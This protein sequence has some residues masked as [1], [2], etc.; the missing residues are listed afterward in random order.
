MKNTSL[1]NAIKLGATSLSHRVVM[2][3]LTRL[4]SDQDGDVP[5][6]LMLEYYRQR[7]SAGGLIITEATAVA[8]NGRGYLGAPGIYS[9][10][11][12]DGW[13]RITD[14]VH[15][16]GGRIFLQLWHV[17]RVSHV[18]MTGGESPVAPSAI[19]FEGAAFT[20]NGWVT[21]SPSR[22]L[23]T[24]EIPGIVE[25]FR[26]AAERARSAGFDGVEV[27]G[28]NGY[29]LDQFLNDGSNRRSDAYGGPVENRARLLLEVT[30]AVASV[31][32]GDRVGVRISP[33]G[34]FLSMSDSNPQATFDY[35]ASA[36]N[37]FGLAYLHIIEPR[38]NGSEVVAEGQAPVASARLRKIFTGPVIAAGGFEAEDAHAAIARGDVDMVAFGRH[39][40]ANP[41]LPKRLE[42]GLP[43]NAYDRSTFYG[44][45]HRGYTDYPEHQG[46]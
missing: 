14:A 17:G 38:V 40:V 26:R 4:R 35:V 30:E 19:P 32:G 37:R 45:D 36:L 28:A 46:A 7:A 41:D 13:R 43:L 11:Q 12:V 5:N 3:P 15:A 20:A 23:E 42:S 25:T 1:F 10:A 31:W 24:H 33:G 39:F 21:P 8:F 34:K 27:H 22:A 18:D 2:A 16:K 29:L 6:A 44:G 9:D